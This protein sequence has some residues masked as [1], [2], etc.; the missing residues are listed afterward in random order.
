MYQ[1]TLDNF[2]VCVFFFFVFQLNLD[3]C[4]E[5]PCQ[6]GTCVNEIDGFFCD[7]ENTGYEG[8]L[9]EY[10]KSKLQEKKEF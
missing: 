2:L 9:C 4:M 6:H 1:C 10:G 5:S 3:Y 8:D 7:C